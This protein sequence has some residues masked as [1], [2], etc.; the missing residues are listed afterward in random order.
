MLKKQLL[1]GLLLVLGCGLQAPRGTLDFLRGLN[2]QFLGETNNLDGFMARPLPRQSV[3]SLNMDMFVECARIKNVLDSDYAETPEA[4]SEE[5]SDIRARADKYAVET[6]KRVCGIILDMRI[7]DVEDLKFVLDS[8]PYQ[9]ILAEKTR[10]SS[11][12]DKENKALR[13]LKQSP[14]NH[15]PAGPAGACFG[16]VKSSSAAAFLEVSKSPRRLSSLVHQL[17]GKPVRGP[18]RLGRTKVPLGCADVCPALGKFK[19]RRLIRDDGYASSGSSGDE[20]R[21]ARRRGGASRAARTP[22]AS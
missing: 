11:E 15:A 17:P 13:R 9:T 5:V 18:S 6:W 20:R 4:W 1:L 2:S 7:A 14:A 10:M 19:P 22:A 16:M 3:I 8:E 12:L 21:P